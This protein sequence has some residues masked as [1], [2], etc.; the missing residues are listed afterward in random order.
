MHPFYRKKDQER[1][2]FLD[3]RVH[4]VLMSENYWMNRV[5]TEKAAEAERERIIVSTRRRDTIWWAS[6]MGAFFVAGLAIDW[7]KTMYAATIEGWPATV[8]LVPFI[9]VGVLLFGICFGI[10]WRER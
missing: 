8:G 2:Y 10:W 3:C 7:W 5:A 9:G 4:T 6:L 1:V